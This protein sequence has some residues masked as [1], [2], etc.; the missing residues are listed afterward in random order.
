MSNF[1]KESID[2]HEEFMR[3][4]SYDTFRGYARELLYDGDYSEHDA[5][6]LRG[7]IVRHIADRAEEE[8][9]DLTADD[10]YDLKLWANLVVEELIQIDRAFHESHVGFYNVNSFG[11][12]CPLNWAELAEYME[13][14]AEDLG[15]DIENDAD[16]AEAFWR[17]FWDEY[18]SVNHGKL[19]NAPELI[20][21]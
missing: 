19:M 9:V 7:A 8:G 11:A 17:Y 18:N 6:Y 15:Y 12:D 2:S 5:E 16:D 13:G 10:L 4:Y 1:Y 14:V 20:E 21:R 3:D